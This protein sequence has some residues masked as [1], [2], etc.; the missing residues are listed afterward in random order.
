LTLDEGIP[1]RTLLAIAA[2]LVVLQAVVLFL[3]GQPPICTCGRIDL[4]HGDPSGP[5]TSQHL[6]DW[7][8][9][10]HVVHGFAF[11]VLLWLM[12]SRWS[13][14]LRFLVALGLEVGWEVLENTPMIIDRYREQALAEG[15]FGDSIVNSIGDTLATVLGF[16]LARIMPVW[17]SVV[18]VI[19]I[20]LSLAFMIRDNLALNIIQLIVPIEA[21]SRWQLGG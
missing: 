11:Y 3:M 2:A 20:E 13:F 21:I 16:V 7:Y 17:S 6:T 14:G 19:G 12:A 15:Y 18:L 8:T 10:T 4:W 1:V 5:E 9:L